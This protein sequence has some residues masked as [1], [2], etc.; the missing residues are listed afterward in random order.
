VFKFRSSPAAG[1]VWFKYATWNV[2][3]L[4][5]KE[6]ELDKIFNFKIILKFQ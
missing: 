6:E 3:G 1:A 4:R 2:R 5:E